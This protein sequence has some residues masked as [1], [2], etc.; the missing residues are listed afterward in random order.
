MTLDKNI[1]FVN[2]GEGMHWRA[3]VELPYSPER[4]PEIIDQEDLIN[5]ESK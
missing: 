2:V 1:F 5:L 3:E 4:C